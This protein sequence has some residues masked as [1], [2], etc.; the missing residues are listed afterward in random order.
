MNQVIKEIGM[1]GRHALEIASTTQ[2]PVVKQVSLDTHMI[3]NA[4]LCFAGFLTI[5][6]AV[7]V[8]ALQA[9][10]ASKPIAEHQGFKPLSRTSR[11]EMSYDGSFMVEYLTGGNIYVHHRR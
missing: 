4:W 9:S 3:S 11:I 7:I 8:P 2:D 1:N 6:A 10:E 5:A